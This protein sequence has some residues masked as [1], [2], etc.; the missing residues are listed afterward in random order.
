MHHHLV[1]CT[2]FVTVVRA[3]GISNSLKVDDK[4]AENAERWFQHQSGL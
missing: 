2:M 4:G 3:I 1:V